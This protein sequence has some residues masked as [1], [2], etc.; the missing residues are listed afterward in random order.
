MMIIV[1]ILAFFGVFSN[2]FI[3]SSPRSL[4]TIA[5]VATY[6]VETNEIS[7]TNENERF[8]LDSSV[9]FWENFQSKETQEIFNDI[10]EIVQRES[11][12]SPKARAYFA[13]Q[14]IRTGYFAVN[15]FAGNFAVELLGQLSG[16]SK[17]AA[18]FDMFGGGNRPLLDVLRETNVPA[19]L[20]FEAAKTFE[21]D[22]Q[23]VE[24]GVIKYPWDALF[25]E[26]GSPQ[27]NHRQA[28]PL[29]A[30]S[31]TAETIREMSGILGRKKKGVANPSSMKAEIY[32]DYYLNDFHFQTDGWLS[33]NSASRYES[34]TESLFLGRQD[35]MQRQSLVPVMKQDVKPNTILEVACGTGRFSTFVRDNLPDAQVTLTDLSPFYLEKA[36]DNDDYWRSFTGRKETSAPATI[37]QANAEDLP[38]PDNS[39]DCVLNVYLFHELPLEAAKKAASEMVRVCK[40]GG[41]IVISDSYQAV[42]RPDLG[43]IV[44]L[45]SNLN[46][47]H[48][49]SYLET[50]LS[51]LFQECD[52]NEK[53]VASATK[54][55]SFIKK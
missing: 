38:F 44:K 53:L 4:T 7:A 18:S 40:P 30:L 33:T 10:I 12:K 9:Q 48:Y 46:E 34:S 26:D 19:R 51:D 28:N 27:L 15:S 20:F 2:G 45:F 54:T 22:W 35:A 14:L 43:A 23:W 32:P 17:S 39:F 47:P 31:E 55:L 1:S 21:Q 24:R 6:D 42:D 41:M 49:E 52:C 5:K 13:S 8:A 25:R 37:L 50:N 29:F 16:D 36:R 11:S 3:V